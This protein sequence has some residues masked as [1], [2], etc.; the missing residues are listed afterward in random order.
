MHPQLRRLLPGLFLNPAVPVDE[1]WYAAL[2]ERAAARVEA[3][4]DDPEGRLALRRDFY[5]RYGYAYTRARGGYG[6]SEL[7]F[8]AWEAARGVL[9]PVAGE[10]P[11]SAWWRDVNAALLLDAETARV[12]EEERLGGVGLPRPVQVW[13]TYIRRPSSQTWYRAHNTSIVAGYFAHADKARAECAYEQAFINEV[14]VRLLYAQ[15]MVEGARYAFGLLGRLLS[16]PRLP[17]VAMITELPDFYPTQYPLSGV[18]TLQDNYRVRILNAMQ[19]LAQ[20]RSV[21]EG[22]EDVG[23]AVLDIAE[24]TLE[25]VFDDRIIAP[26]LQRLFSQAAVWLGE[27]RLH[28]IL[29]DGLPKYPSCVL[30]D[31]PAPDAE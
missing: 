17:S 12:L 31:K 4:I 23:G 19:D 28:T 3:V 14:L 26:H 22:I 7:A 30:D 11:G 25:V 5:E 24:H 6:N 27:P 13:L 9:N 16:K 20:D 18:A 2:R 15:A 8:L 21:L 10:K 29:V 1:T